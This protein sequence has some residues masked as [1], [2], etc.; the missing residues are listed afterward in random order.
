MMERPNTWL[1]RELSPVPLCAK[2][3]K[4]QND[5]TLRQHDFVG[6]DVG[7]LAIVNSDWLGAA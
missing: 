4:N 3:T 2:Q 6:F 1:K 7:T 5:R